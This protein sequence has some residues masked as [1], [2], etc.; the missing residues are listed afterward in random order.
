[1]CVLVT[2][3][4]LYVNRIYRLNGQ[5]DFCID[6][7]GKCTHAGIIDRE[8]IPL[9]IIV[10]DEIFLRQSAIYLESPQ[11]QYFDDHRYFMLDGQKFIFCEELGKICV[12]EQISDRVEVRS[13]E[14]TIELIRQGKDFTFVE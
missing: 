1:M 4:T 3:I 11:K 14:K 12:Y 5:G 9:I 8:D 7:L 2:H 13:I 6:L 10:Y